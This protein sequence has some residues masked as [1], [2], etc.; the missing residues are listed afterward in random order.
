M[1][2]NRKLKPRNGT[3]KMLPKVATL[4]AMC[5]ADK[6]PDIYTLPEVKYLARGKLHR[7]PSSA[8]T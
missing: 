3:F 2:R 7:E 6:N 1:G 8:I 5:R 4:P